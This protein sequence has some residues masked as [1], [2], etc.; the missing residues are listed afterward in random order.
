MTPRAVRIVVLVVCGVGIAGMIGGS[1]ADNNGFAMSAGVI[2]AIAVLNVI[3]ATAV[4]RP[5]RPAEG[6]AEAAA[7]QVEEHVQGLMRQGVEE[8]ALRDLA[9]AAIRL[10][11][12]G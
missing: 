6:E 4:A 9:R 5:P 2:T 8:A 11:R 12:A 3:V 7:A 10:G 1:I